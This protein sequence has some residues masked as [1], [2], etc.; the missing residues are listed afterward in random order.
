MNTHM[1]MHMHMLQA[2][3]VGAA[4]LAEDGVT[5]C[6]AGE[7]DPLRVFSPHAG[8]RVLRV[9][10]F[11]GGPTLKNVPA[12]GAPAPAP[13]PACRLSACVQLR[14]L[15]LLCVGGDTG[16]LNVYSVGRGP[17]PTPTPTPT[18]TPTPTP[19]PSPTRDQVP[20]VSE[21]ANQAIGPF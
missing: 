9:A 11:P 15:D 2:G 14:G 19:T 4:M 12:I 6:T 10:A 8:G 1:H 7:A 18:R 16:Q 5:I 20:V 17:S 13:A 3:P 21:A